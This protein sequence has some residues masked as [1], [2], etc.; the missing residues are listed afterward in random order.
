V[1]IEGNSV[2][3][4]HA[5]ARRT[6]RESA[7]P[8]GHGACWEAAMRQETR[9]VSLLAALVLAGCCAEMPYCP[10]ADYSAECHDLNTRTSD[11]DERK[12][13]EQKPIEPDYDR[14]GGI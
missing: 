13:E 12:A 2:P 11:G 10:T 3:A 9:L 4:K 1:S 8:A 7:F 5:A 14:R 6:R